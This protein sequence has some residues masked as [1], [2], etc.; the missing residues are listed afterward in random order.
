MR[1]KHT[2]CT[3]QLDL[4]TLALHLYHSSFHVQVSLNVLTPF[5]TLRTN[6]RP[7]WVLK[8]SFNSKD[9]NLN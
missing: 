9:V 7:P 4:H 8:S 5:F 1:R 2:K 6:Q 3:I